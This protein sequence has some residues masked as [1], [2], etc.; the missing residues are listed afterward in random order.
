MTGL[1]NWDQLWKTM[2]INT[3]R[4]VLFEKDFWENNATNHK[5][6][7]TQMTELTNGQ[8]SRLQLL[9]ECTVLDIGAGTGRLAIPLAKQVKQVTAVE[10]SVNRAKLLKENIEKE[11]LNNITLVN[12]PWEELSAGIDILPHDIVLASYSFFMANLEN[13]LKKMDTL[14]N[15]R[16]YIFLSA[17]KPNEDEIQKIMC[18]NIS[19]LQMA[20]YMYVYNSLH[21][22]GIFANVE[23]WNF[24]SEESYNNM[25]EA[26]AKISENHSIQPKTEDSLRAY[27]QKNL[28]TDNEG[29]LHLKRK[30]KSAMIWWDKKD[31]L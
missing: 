28:I 11:K 22:L 4:T 10:P 27:L 3:N 2:L 17:I 23:L 26:V 5:E 20:D 24:N 6:D 14:T 9:P 1:I 18:G 7:A 19:P 21:D 25:N 15:K 13:A 29:K 12:R 31:N 16:A 30:R 8:L